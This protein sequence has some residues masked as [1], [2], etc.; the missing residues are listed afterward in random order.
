MDQR[1][2][3]VALVRDKEFL[4]R[5]VGAVL[6]LTG[7]V[8]AA[9]ASAQQAP[10]PEVSFPILVTTDADDE[11]DDEEVLT[12]GYD[13]DAADS[14]IDRPFLEEELP[15][16]PPSDVFAVRLIDVDVPPSG[17]GE[18][19][20]IDI[21]Q[22]APAFTGTKE[23]EIQLQPGAGTSSV[24][25]EWNLPSGVTGTL[26]D[27]V[28]DGGEV[29]EPME[30]QGSYTLTNTD[31]TELFVTLDY[32]GTQPSVNI[33]SRFV[34]EDEIFDFKNTGA[35]IRFS[36]VGPSGA[37]TLTKYRNG[38]DGT[39]N[40]TENNVSNYRYVIESGGLSFSGDAT[41]C[42]ADSTLAGM[43]DPSAVQ[44]YQRDSPGTGTFESIP[45]NASD[46]GT[47]VVATTSALGEFVL[48]SNTEPLPVE[49]TDVT[50]TRDGETALVQWQTAT[51]TNNAG[52]EVQHRGPGA[53]DYAEVGYVE[54]KA[55]GGTTTQPTSYRYEV[56]DLNPGTHQFRL[57]Q[58]DTDGTAHLS[59]TVSLT[60]GME[61]SLRLT[62]PSPNPVRTSTQIRFGVR[63]SAPAT[64]ELY[65]VLGQRVATLYDGTPAP[66]EMQTVRLGSQE[67][68]G[69]PSGVYFVRLDADGASRTRRLTVVR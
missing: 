39:D 10:V 67:L 4:R 34:G 49:F 61:Q 22:G 17:F 6:L 26:K 25:F 1:D 8:V 52:F 59:E 11:A 51:E 28:T 44:V 18:G 48:A 57:R 19:L 56:A 63:G 29:N 37:V 20:L 38:P 46:D 5:C 13:T 58:V 27:V 7:L 65:N 32:D 2:R 64:V 42:L 54:S 47:E 45:T 69:V 53:E 3:R 41:L 24:T 40:I 12:F 50:V 62:G 33:Q 60:V 30:E 31:I 23:H 9:P 36:G 55:G 15:P 68:A 16:L 35:D 21:R 14:N 66:G 43:D